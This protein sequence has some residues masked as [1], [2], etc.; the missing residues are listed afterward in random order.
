MHLNVRDFEYCQATVRERHGGRLEAW[1]GAVCGA[2]AG[3][4]AAGC[5]TPLDVAKTRIMLA[6]V[7]LLY[8][9]T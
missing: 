6:N 8:M 1:Q 9:Y 4:I 2:V 3:G 7:R 5:T